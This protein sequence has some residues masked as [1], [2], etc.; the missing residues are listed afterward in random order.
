MKLTDIEQFLASGW[1]NS[2]K[3]NISRLLQP[4]Q[5]VIVAV[6][7]SPVEVKFPGIIAHKQI[8]LGSMALLKLRLVV[9]DAGDDA[10]SVI[11]SNVQQDKD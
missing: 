2:D 11:S 6:T 1:T 8:K 10:V 5:T 7:D 9:R 3:I 4:G